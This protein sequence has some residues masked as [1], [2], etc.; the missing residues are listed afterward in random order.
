MRRSAPTARL[1]DRGDTVGVVAPGFAVRRA[2]VEEGAARLRRMGFRVVFGEHL[3]ARH[4]YFAGDD[5]ARAADLRAMIVDPE[6]RAIWFARGGY[7][8][9]R[10]LDRI[11]WRTLKRRPKLFIGYSDVTALLCAAVQRTGQ[12]S[13]HGPFV[14]ELGRREAY[15]APSLRRALAGE[16]TVLRLRAGQVLAGGKARGRLLGGNL[17]VLAHAQGT[18]YAPDLRGCVLLLEEVGEEAYRIDRALH[19]LEMAGAFRDLAGV[20][21]GES[22]VP[23]TGR[24][25]PP[26]RDLVDVLEERLA[27][28]GVP[29]VY[30]LPAGHVAGKHTLPLGGTVRL[31]TSA[32]EVRFQP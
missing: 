16:G 18:R 13:L 32:R 5:D 12:V 19:H 11:P 22:P 31:D 2:P 10:I 1:L 6:V 24:S 7:G 15:H 28:L 3:F 23:R 26:D 14:S 29:V 30:G 9:A 8:T 25:F 4:G 20:L 27:P 17:T 21:V